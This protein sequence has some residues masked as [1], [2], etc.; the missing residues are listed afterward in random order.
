MIQFNIKT[1]QGAFLTLGITFI[2]ILILTLSSLILRHAETSEER[3]YELGSFEKFY[4]TDE[5][6]RDTY[7]EMVEKILNMHVTSTFNA[8]G[9]STTRV[10][11]TKKMYNTTDNELR[12]FIDARLILFYLYGIVL[13]PQFKLKSLSTSEMVIR[14]APNPLNYRYYYSA[15]EDDLTQTIS[16]TNIVYI[17]QIDQNLT[18]LEIHAY[19]NESLPGKNAS[20]DWI[21]Y[22]DTN[23]PNL[24]PFVN[25]TFAVHGPN[26]WVDSQTR[27]SSFGNPPTAQKIEIGNLTGLNEPPT[28]IAGSSS[29]IFVNGDEDLYTELI[30][31]F[32]EGKQVHVLTKEKINITFPALISIS[33]EGQIRL[34]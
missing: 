31:T 19:Y 6:I 1:K 14:F 15:D 4:I 11:I 24:P 26:G 17:T 10:N 32:N 29:F 34:A 9:D 23:P 22:F 33:K 7:N 3:I 30:L 20:V 2:S 16:E 28:L 18:A 25:L 8:T 12:R 21:T 13:D 5:S 27:L